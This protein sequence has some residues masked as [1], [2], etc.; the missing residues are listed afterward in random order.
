VAYESGNYQPN[1]RNRAIL[2]RAWEHVQAVPY[3]VTARWLF[4]RLLQ[5]GYYHKKQ[6]YKNRFLKL[7]SA[8]RH[9]RYEGWRPYTLADDQR[10]AVIRGNGFLTAE[11]WGQAIAENLACNLAR[12]DGQKQYLEIWFEAGAMLAQFR[13]YT[14]SITLRPFFGMPSI[15]YKWDIAKALEAAHEKHGLPLAVLYFGDLDPA[16]ET[17]P[18]TSIA[19]IRKWCGVAFEWVRCGLNP[20][21]ER[22]HNIPENPDKPGTYQWEALEDKAAR[23]LIT[24]AVGQ[25]VDHGVMAQI[26]EREAIATA[27]FRKYA[28][29]F[30]SDRAW[31]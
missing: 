6:D 10:E 3:Q 15:P 11:S 5:E 20:G 23:E 14:E 30:V 26:E 19:D 13:H 1:A 8:A 25:Y 9:N 27:A 7:L 2:A 29:R 17:I 16:G 4:Y 22:Q 18:E 24:G 12:W 31:E 21:H 28:R